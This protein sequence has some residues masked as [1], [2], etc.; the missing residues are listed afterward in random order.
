MKKTIYILLIA[1]FSVSLFSCGTSKSFQLEK[2]EEVT[3]SLKAKKDLVKQR[4]SQAG[5]KT[6]LAT[7]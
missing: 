2:N 1:M 5:K 4:I 3:F 7:P 6:I